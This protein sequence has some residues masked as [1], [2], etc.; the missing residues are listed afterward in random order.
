MERPS[1]GD[2]RSGRYPA[3]LNEGRSRNMRANR[4]T[5][6][7]P[8]IRLR[9]ALHRLGY[10]FRKDLRLDLG[11][12]KI[13]PDIVFTARKVAIFV[14]G[15]FWHVCPEHGRQP[16]TNE[17]YWAPKLERNVD[18]DRAADIALSHAGWKVVRL[19]EHEPLDV[20]VEAV[21]GAL[22]NLSRNDEMRGSEP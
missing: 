14:D 18:R 12:V 2:S 19:W 16:T 7:K 15:C 20:S 3:A 5:D 1:N 21:L 13:R 11:A 22:Q 8:E 6:T 9:S 4:R 10:R 17:W